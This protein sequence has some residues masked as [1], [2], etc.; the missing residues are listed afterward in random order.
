ME[1]ELINN[2]ID[3]IRADA[4]NQDFTAIEVMLEL[5][6]TIDTRT[7]G[8]ICAILNGYIDKD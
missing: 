4:I 3:G 8:R 1:R 5:L 6:I 2:V 7:Q